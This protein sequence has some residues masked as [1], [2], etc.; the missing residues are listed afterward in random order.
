MGK[1][2]KKKNSGNP[3]L[4]N[5][6]TLQTTVTTASKRVHY[7]LNWSQWGDITAQMNNS[8]WGATRE[9]KT[10]HPEARRGLAVMKLDQ[11]CVSVCKQCQRCELRV[12]SRSRSGYERKLCRAAGSPAAPV[13][14]GHWG[15]R[16][17]LLSLS[18]GLFERLI[19]TSANTLRDCHMRGRGRKPGVSHR[20]M[21]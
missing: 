21:S 18:A 6:V 10:H 5:R 19:L 4:S 3:T 12:C 11:P 2:K 1:L 8:E 17:F 16:R 9:R 15:P 13:C 20:Q 14:L 7:R